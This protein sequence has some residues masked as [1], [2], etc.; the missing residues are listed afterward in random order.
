MVKPQS[1]KVI[2]DLK[3]LEQFKEI[4]SYLEKK[5]EQAPKIVKKEII[6]RIRSIQKNPLICEFD[7]L[8][9]PPNNEFRAFIVFS[10]RLSYQIKADQN[11]VRILR[12]RHTS[13]EPL[14]Y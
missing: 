6:N 9:D 8:K 7:K 14:G 5:S 3:A 11:E 1:F 10:Y 12:I 4:L 2:W 13:R